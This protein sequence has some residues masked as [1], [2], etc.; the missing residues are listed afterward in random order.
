[1]SDYVTDTKSVLDQAIRI[2]Q[3]IID[4]ASDAG[5]LHTALNAMR[6]M[7]M[8]MQGRFLTDSPLTTLPH[9]DAEVAG[10]LRRGG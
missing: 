8:V 4:V 7:Q 2:I 9:V 5:W 6:L 3:A 10:K 1:M